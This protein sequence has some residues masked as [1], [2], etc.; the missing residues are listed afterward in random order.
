MHEEMQI[1]ELLLKSVDKANED[2][3]EIKVGMG[4]LTTIAQNTQIILDK[5][6]KNID[7]HD[8]RIWRLETEHAKAKGVIGALSAVG[9]ISMI[10]MIKTFFHQ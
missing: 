1:T 3:A 8:S 2:I 5:I 9:I 6:E 4:K 10:N 7:K